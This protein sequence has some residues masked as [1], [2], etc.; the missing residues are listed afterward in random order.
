MGLGENELSYDA[1]LFVSFGGPEGPADVMPFLRNVVRG[2]NVP[3]ERLLEVAAH[4]GRFGG[5]SPINQQNRDLIAALTREMQRYGMNMPIY[6]GNRNWKPY[7]TDAVAQ[8][9]SDGIHRAMAFVTS[10]FSSYSGCR[11]Y[12]DNISDAVAQAG[13]GGPQIDKLR[14]F[15]NHPLF[16]R[17]V[18]ENVEAALQR[19]PAS[20]RS[21]AQV[22]YTA[23]SIPISMAEGCDY[24][25]QLHESCR[26]VSEALGRTGDRLAYQS[27]SGPPSQPWLEPDVLAA[28]R[29][30]KSSNTFQSVVIAPIGF[31]SD[32]IEVLFD[33]DV[34]ARSECDELQLPMERAA[35][36]STNPKFVRMIRELIQERMEGVQARAT[37]GAFGPG[38]D[39]CLPDCCPA[40]RRP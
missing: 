33:L 36:V 38:P 40:P 1:L 22:L 11:Q 19:L 28:L 24:A 23:H 20:V 15:Y 7:V 17:A 25:R 16:I 6:W 2:R 9:K 31:V 5:C 26:L 18:S 14:V 4:Y 32:H 39:H 21:G 35:T 12:L 34:E 10:A 37:L 30:V 27:R 29:D 8:M 13:H 3:E